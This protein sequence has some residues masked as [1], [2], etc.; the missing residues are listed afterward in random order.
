MKEPHK[1]ESSSTLFGLAYKTSKKLFPRVLSPLFFTLAIWIIV[2]AIGFVWPLSLLFTFPLLFA[3]SS[4]AFLLSVNALNMDQEATPSSYFLYFTRFFSRDVFGSYRLLRNFFLSLLVSLFLAFIFGTL[5]IK[6]VSSIDPSF[7]ESF[8]TLLEYQRAGNLEALQKL[9]ETDT[10][11][12]S[13]VFYLS[14]FFFSSFFLLYLHFFLRSGIVPLILRGSGSF[15]YRVRLAVY[16]LALRQKGVHYNAYYYGAMMP[17]YLFIMGFFVL[18]AYVSSL[19]L[20]DILSQ[21]IFIVMGGVSG[22]FLGLLLV[23]PF[24]DEVLYGLAGRYEV[25]F[26]KTSLL[27][28]EEA[29]HQFSTMKN[30]A[31]AQMKMAE[32]NIELV[33]KMMEE[34][35][36]ATEEKETSSEKE[37]EKKK[38]EDSNDPK[39]PNKTE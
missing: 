19:F 31:D 2:V 17:L 16:S 21:P 12:L 15:P 11:L 38:D 6:G 20:E 3:P 9:L 1:P 37:E 18:G 29:L 4:F 10:S 35:K 27:I 33:K 32:Q 14:T 34:A 24:Y 13:F 30:E 22:A 28:S 39:N 8:D 7:T 36:K 23:L 5:Y 25:L 26:N